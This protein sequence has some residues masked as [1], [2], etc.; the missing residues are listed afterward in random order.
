MIIIVN[1][2]SRETA[3]STNLA[4]LVATLTDAKSGI[5]VALNDEVVPRPSWPAVALMP[6]ARVEV[7]TAVQGG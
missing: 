7:L 5:A 6:G 3:E 2:Q 1:G 4:E